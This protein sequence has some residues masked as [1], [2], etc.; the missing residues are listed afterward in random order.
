MMTSPDPAP[1][2]RW[3]PFLSILLVQLVVVLA[4][5]LLWPSLR[6]G[7]RGWAVWLVVIVVNLF[8]ARRYIAPGPAA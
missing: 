4:T 5:V 3:V 6:T 1:P 7:W 8:A 2:R